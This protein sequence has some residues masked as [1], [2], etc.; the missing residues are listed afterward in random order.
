M[1][2]ID[3]LISPHN[4][5]LRQYVHFIDEETEARCSNPSKVTQLFNDGATILNLGSLAPG[6]F[7]CKLKADKGG[8]ILFVQSHPGRAQAGTL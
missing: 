6:C 4:S 8:W 1:L 3:G 7:L 2:N 5:P